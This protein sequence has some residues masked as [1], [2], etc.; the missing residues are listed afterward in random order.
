MH[1]EVIQV[2]K[3]P[4]MKIYDGVEVKLRAR[5]TL[6]VHGSDWVASGCSHFTSYVELH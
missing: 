3:H 4:I 2:I 5:L 6:A 1:G